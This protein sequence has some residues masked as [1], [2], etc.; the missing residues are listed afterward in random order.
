L[1][2]RFTHKI[3]ACFFKSFLYLSN[4]LKKPLESE[5]L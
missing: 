2:I 3:K 1:F 5:N 4:I